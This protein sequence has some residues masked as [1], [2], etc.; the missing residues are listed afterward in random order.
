MF[1][2]KNALRPGLVLR[3]FRYPG[4]QSLKN[5][6]LSCTLT[7]LLL[8]IVSVRQYFLSNEILRA[9]CSFN[10]T[11]FADAWKIFFVA[12]TVWSPIP[13]QK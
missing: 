4:S 3:Q 11:Q 1:C 9:Q 13:N 10:L 2:A 6:N 12:L 8:L 5:H 7:S